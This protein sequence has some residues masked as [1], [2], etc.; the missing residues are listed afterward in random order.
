MH[1]LAAADDLV[2]LALLGRGAREPPRPYQR[3]AN[4]P[5]IDQTRS[6]LVVCNL[7]CLNPRF[8]GVCRIHCRYEASSVQPRSGTGIQP[9]ASAPG[10]VVHMTCCLQAPEGRRLN[11]FN[12]KDIARHNRFRALAATREAHPEKFSADDVAVPG[13]ARKLALFRVRDADRKCRI[14]ALPFKCPGRRGLA[15]SHA[16]DFDLTILT[17]VATEG[18][19]LNRTTR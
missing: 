7:D 12:P 4:S 3:Y 16:E 6:N 13:F 9:G 5:A 15:L 8:V 2:V 10:I 11:I 18:S 1:A 17:M 14:T 19:D